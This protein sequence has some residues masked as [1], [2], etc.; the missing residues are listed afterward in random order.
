MKNM[1]LSKVVKTVAVEGYS[2]DIDEKQDKVLQNYLNKGYFLIDTRMS[3][4]ET[5]VIILFLFGFKE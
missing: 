2:D 3:A 1:N 4:T 5:K